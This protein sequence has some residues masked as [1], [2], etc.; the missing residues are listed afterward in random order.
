MVG[1]RTKSGD[2]ET[3]T[4]RTG[5]S[6]SHGAAPSVT[7]IGIGNW[8]TALGCALHGAGVPML[9]IVV[10]QGPKTD[11]AANRK[12]A[13]TWGARLTTLE[14]A[15][16]DADVLWICTPDASIARTAG[17]LAARIQ[18]T[19]K[20]GRIQQVAFH[21][22][23]AL[24]SGELAAL[25]ILGASVASVH[26]LMTF[27]RRTR[28]EFLHAV[29]SRENAQYPLAGVPF[30]L[31]GDARACRAARRLLRVLRG[32]PFMLHERDKPLY[33]AFGVFTSPLLIAVLTAAAETGAA[34]GLNPNDVRRLMR[35]IVERTI[36]NFFS[37]GPEK[38]FSG[39]LAR[40]DADTVAGHLS[41]FRGHAALDA[42][43]RQLSRYALAALPGANKAQL[44][45]L[46]L[47]PPRKA[48]SSRR[49]TAS[50]A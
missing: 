47:G 48:A 45:K 13:H 40:G 35:P 34:A 17:E 44:R 30:A 37:D 23:G 5:R 14:R 46:L 36:A 2:V 3:P 15:T 33:H 26:P 21:S 6:P 39:P 18:S 10:R 1:Q 25:K 22:S 42:T 19:G 28:K 12:L 32:I 24:A 4:P 8:G 16:L 38:S 43:Y 49:S 50:T 20:P 41:A 9:E 11:I 29:R 31:Q 27:P 7:L